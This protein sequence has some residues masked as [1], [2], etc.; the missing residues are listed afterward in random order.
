M[1]SPSKEPLSSPYAKASANDK[2]TGVSEIR[3]TSQPSQ[4]AQLEPKSSPTQIEPRIAELVKAPA[5][6]ESRALE[7]RELSQPSDGARSGSNCSTTQIEPRVEEFI[8]AQ[9]DER[10]DRAAE[11]SQP[12]ES[13]GST[14]QAEPRVEEFIRARA[15]EQEV[16]A[17]EISES[18]HDAPS[19]S[20]G[21]T[22]QVE[23]RVAEFVRQ[24]AIGV[25][26]IPVEDIATV[27][28]RAVPAAPDA[29]LLIHS[30]YPD[31]HD[32]RMNPAITRLSGITRGR[33]ILA[34]AQRLHDVYFTVQ[35]SE[36][37]ELNCQVFYDPGSDDC[38]F[39]N[40]SPEHIEVQLCGISDPGALFVLKSKKGQSV[41]PGIW[42]IAAN[43]GLDHHPL[44]EFLLLEKPFNVSIHK[45]NTPL[46]KR[47]ADADVGKMSKRQRLEN[48]MPAEIIATQSTDSLLSK[49]GSTETDLGSTREIVDKAAVPLLDLAD[50][51][52]AVIKVHPAATDSG[53]YRLQRIKQ[54]GATRST[55]VFS[56][57]HSGLPKKRLVVKVLRYN[58]N[59][60]LHLPIFARLWETE[61]SLLQDL[62]HRNVVALEAFDGR[63]FAIYLEL[64]PLSLCRGLYSPFT[65]P[66]AHMILLNMS[67]AL[68]YLANLGIVHNDIKPANIA[69]NPQ[70]G[71]VLFDFGMACKIE[72]RPGGGTPWYLP[73]DMIENKNRGLPGDIWAMGVTMLYVLQKIK[74]PERMTR[75]WNLRELVPPVQKESSAFVQM[76]DWL[77]IVAEKRAE[78]NKKDLVE[79]AVFQ[80]LDTDG[81]LR[82]A[83]GG[84]EEALK[85]P[86]KAY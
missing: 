64:L 14:T 25:P 68:S 31:G 30:D 50:R 10:D 28:T 82:A 33:E 76:N 45:A 16:I 3:E 71:A 36:P 9:A 57:R 23:P 73:P 78:L 59:S 26:N 61:K 21:S 15:N 83:A 46:I 1:S 42:R 84:I 58:G 44:F 8:R 37:I 63:M 40:L 69:Y 80:M 55:L 2:E 65:Q 6:E 12:S 7:V 74:M 29:R 79:N 35:F 75:G 13:N 47:A 62:K 51:E 54:L 52:T 85:V 32:M 27:F 60:P 38:F 53:T 4:D 11:T 24:Q 20:N 39:I 43:Q 70:R 86:L 48:R 72:E 34:V 19:E 41:Q 81:A 49:S 66:D 67:S 5:N 22:T 18:S 56:C 17:A 77:N